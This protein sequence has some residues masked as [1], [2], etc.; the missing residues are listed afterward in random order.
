MSQYAIKFSKE[1]YICYTSHLDMLRL[2]KRALKKAGIKLSYSQGFNPHPKMGFAQPLSLGYSSIGEYLEFETDEDYSESELKKAL[3]RQMPEGVNLFECKKLIGQKKSLAA[4]TK[5][6]EYII[7]IPLGREPKKDGQTLC[8]EFLKQKEILVPKKQ[9][10][11]KEMKDVNIRDKIR[12][13]NF[14]IAGE[15]LLVTAILDCGSESNLSP[16]L[17]IAALTRFL[18][19][20]TDRSEMDVLRTKIHFN[21]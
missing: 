15:N 16:E 20:D 19:V 8:E 18:M 21:D 17:L 5:S 3:D 6:A 7:G 10:K 14:V 4:R 11:S 1:G 13:L 2:F 12:L 9:K